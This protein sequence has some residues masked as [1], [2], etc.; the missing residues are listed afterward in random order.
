LASTQSR[1]YLRA[2]GEIVSDGGTA[3]VLRLLDAADAQA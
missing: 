3:A 1:L 2:W